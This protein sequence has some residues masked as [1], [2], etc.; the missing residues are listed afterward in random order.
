[1]PAE[2]ISLASPG[3]APSF[4]ENVLGCV[5]RHLSAIESRDSFFD[6][7]RPLLLDVRIRRMKRLEQD[8]DEPGAILSGQMP[9][10]LFEFFTMKQT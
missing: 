4:R 5:G 3:Q 9:D 8:L 10:L 6:L 1:M 2:R 7:S